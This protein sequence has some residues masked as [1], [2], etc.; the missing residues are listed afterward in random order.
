MAQI[1]RDVHL[2]SVVIAGGV[3]AAIGI[4]SDPFAFADMSM[5]AV[6]M[7]PAAVASPSSPRASA[8][9]LSAPAAKLEA[10]LE[11][12][13]QKH[14]LPAL[15][16]AVVTTEG[17]WT[18]AASGVR[19]A[20]REEKVTAGD[21][22][23]LGSC[24]KA[25]TA[26]LC[27]ILVEEGV[28]RWDTTLAE[29]LPALKG[30]MH[31][32][33][34]GITMAELL[35]QRSGVPADMNRDGLWMKLWQ[36]DADVMT[37]RAECTRTM[38]SWGPAHEKSK[39]EYSNANFI[40]A[41]HVL[42]T[43][44]GKSWEE[45]MRTKL[46]EPLGMSTAGFG[47]PGAEGKFDQPQGHRSPTQAV[48]LGRGSDNPPALGPAGTVHASLEDWGKFISLHLRGEAAAREGKGVAIAGVMI[49][50]ETWRLM[51]TRAVGEGADYAMGWGTGERP[52]AQGVEG[53]KRVIT[54][55]GSNTMWMCVVWA[56]PD[57][58]FAVLSA[59]NIGG[60]AA[61]KACDDASGALIGLY[62]SEHPVK[63]EKR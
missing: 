11:K 1:G 32:G 36:D 21:L 23:H 37:K 54:H 60:D 33:Y 48:G 63:P 42:E 18:V 35:T 50:P 20:G 27:A 47:A 9:G 51:H 13:R 34:R 55:S 14:G 44:T 53:A 45:L 25:M 17:L 58:G 41:G 15:A 30:T 40:I 38:L 46:F 49:R 29:A 52:W 39:F 56:A 7:Q 57:A 31:E 2:S 5:P 26:T 10:E 8:I 12:I 61:A 3:V 62:R 19:V 28:L 16:G 59:T 43:L 24:T 22:F 6:L 4:L